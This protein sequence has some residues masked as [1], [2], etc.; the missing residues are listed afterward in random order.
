MAKNNLRIVLEAYAA[1]GLDLSG[2][3]N[4]NETATKPDKLAI[5]T[6]LHLIRN[7]FASQVVRRE[8]KTNRGR[9]KPETVHSVLFD[10]ATLWSTLAEFRIETLHEEMRRLDSAPDIYSAAVDDILDAFDDEDFDETDKDELEN[11]QNADRLS[12]IQQKLDAEIEN[13]RKM[14]GKESYQK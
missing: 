3:I 2:V 9:V 7:K 12:E 13:D 14:K 1:A 11:H 10:S 4:V 6:A 5:I 8:K